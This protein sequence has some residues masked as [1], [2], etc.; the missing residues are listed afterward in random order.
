MEKIIKVQD[1]SFSNFKVFV[2]ANSQIKGSIPKWLSGCKKLQML[3][4]S[5]NHLSGSIPSWFG[6]FD[7]LF[8]LD[9]SNNSFSGNIPEFDNGL[10]SPAQELFIR[11]NS[12]WLWEWSTKKF[13]VFHHLWSSVTTSFKDTWKAYMWCTE[14]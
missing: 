1:L 8:Y 9:L 11:C 5:W 13:Q 12:L 4:L 6:K 10:E 14:A 3:D 2:L 7:N